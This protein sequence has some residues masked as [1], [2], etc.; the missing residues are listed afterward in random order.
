LTTWL[1]LADLRVADHRDLIAVDIESLGHEMYLVPGLN[2]DEYTKMMRQKVI[3]D[4]KLFDYRV[5]ETG[6]TWTSEEIEERRLERRK[7]GDR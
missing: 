7:R 4:R 2:S 1:T 5:K 3:D 6:K